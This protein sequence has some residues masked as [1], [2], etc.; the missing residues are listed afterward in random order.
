MTDKSIHVVIPAY[1]EE[2]NIVHVVE[3]LKR[4]NMGLKIWVVD[5]GSRDKTAKKAR[6]TGAEVLRH[7]L[8]LGQWAALRT[9]FIIAIMEG[10][11]I[12]VSIDADGQHD[13]RDLP[14]LVQPILNGE[15]DVV[16]GSRFLNAEKPKMANYRYYGIKVFNWLIKV[17]TGKRLTDCT[18]GYKAYTAEAIRKLLPYL[19]ENQYG[20]L[21]FIIKTMKQKFRVL[22]KPIKTKNNTVSR[23]GKL[24]YGYHL[25]RTIIKELT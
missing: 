19:R 1:M 24:R 21:E 7:S 9:G 12:L 23:K 10:A 6:M 11:E 4:L 16:I 5:D 22:E 14:E 18:C 2:N 8:N 17:M 15:A 13:P 20:A 25:L 3:E